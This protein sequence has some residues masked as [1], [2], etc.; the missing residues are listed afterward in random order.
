MTAVHVL[1][2][3]AGLVVAIVLSDLLGHRGIG[4]WPVGLLALILVPVA[5]YF[6][7]PWI[8]ALALGVGLGA[9]S[10]LLVPIVRSLLDGRRR[11]RPRGS[12]RTR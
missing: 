2:L 10:M 3:V 9:V 12:N 11:P 7:S 4:A 6:Y 5:G 1:V 8:A